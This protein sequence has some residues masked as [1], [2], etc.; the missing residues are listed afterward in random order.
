MPEV[1]RIAPRG[2]RLESEQ[3]LRALWLDASFTRDGRSIGEGK[4]ASGCRKELACGSE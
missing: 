3:G 4:I 1:F 2:N